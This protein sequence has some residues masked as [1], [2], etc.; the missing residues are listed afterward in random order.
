MKKFLLYLSAVALFLSSCGQTSQAVIEGRFPGLPDA[1][2]WVYRLDVSRMTLVDSVF[3]NSK[4]DFSKRVK[5]PAGQPDFYYLVDGE[6][7]VASMLLRA[8]DKLR[9]SVHAETGVLSVS[10][11][12]ETRILHEAEAGMKAAQHSYDSLMQLY[13][14]SEE[15]SERGR[16]LSQALG[17]VYVKQKQASIRFIFVN[18]K[19]LAS[20]QLLY[21]KFSEEL[22]LFADVLD[23]LYFKHLHDSLRLVYP[24]SHYI[25]VLKN[26]YEQ[27]H[28]NFGLVGKISEAKEMSYPDLALP[29]IK[30]ELVQLSSLQGR[31]IL[32]SFWLSGDVQH[33]LLNQDLLAVYKQYA[34]KGFEIY[35]VA[36]DTDKTAWAKAVSDQ[37]LPWISVCDGRGSNSTAV[38]SYAVTQVPSNFLIDKEG[39]IVGRD[40]SIE[41]LKAQL[42]KICK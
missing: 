19:A 33:R 22:P 41:V 42:A 5:V 39:N 18:A 11:S 6:T 35:Q 17:R 27:R 34:P 28:R 30:A 3:T 38:T 36:V 26:E 9:L 8:G 20:V 12:E 21:N 23:G 40:L 2:L 14:L 32:L 31:P 7:T 16:E 25:A 10:G 4:G 29:D 13:V 37:Q 15:G 1:R 24:R